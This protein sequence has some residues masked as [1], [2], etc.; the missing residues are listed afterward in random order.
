MVTKPLTKPI[1]SQKAS[2]EAFEL[3][4]PSTKYL[5]PYYDWGLLYVVLFTNMHIQIHTN[6]ILPVSLYDSFSQAIQVTVVILM[7]NICIVFKQSF[8][9]PHMVILWGSNQWSD[10]EKIVII[11]MTYV[12]LL[13]SYKSINI[14]TI[15][16][17]LKSWPY[18]KII[19]HFLAWAYTYLQSMNIVLNQWCRLDYDSIFCLGHFS[20]STN[21]QWC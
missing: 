14:W 21:L 9:N 8:D 10:L 5:K 4:I 19:I 12:I 13:H 17:I 2:I 3:H 1:C 15:V 18:T 6:H 16:F 11:R 7:S 20:E